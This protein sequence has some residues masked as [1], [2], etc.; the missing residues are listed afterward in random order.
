MSVL[1]YYSHSALTMDDAY[2][3]YCSVGYGR[4]VTLLKLIFIRIT[5]EHSGCICKVAG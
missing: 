2:M 3:Q 4:W 5:K 1:K